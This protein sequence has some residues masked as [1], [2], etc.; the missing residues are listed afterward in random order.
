[1]KKETNVGRSRSWSRSWSRSRFFQAGVGVGVGVVE[2]WSTPQPWD[3]QGS[4]FS[5]RP[6]WSEGPRLPWQ[7]FLSVSAHISWLLWGFRAFVPRG[8]E[9]PKGAHTLSAP[10]LRPCPLGYVPAGRVCKLKFCKLTSW[11]YSWQ[12]LRGS[13]S[14]GRGLH[15]ISL[16]ISAFRGRRESGKNVRKPV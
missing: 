1:M 16:V 3:S 11:P 8:P 5:G 4:C 12:A 13:V 14:C 7:V 6:G 2:I 10:W 15:K 9:T